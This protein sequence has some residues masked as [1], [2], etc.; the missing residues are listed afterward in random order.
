MWGLLSELLNDHLADLLAAQLLRF[1]PSADPGL[2]DLVSVSIVWAA[3][4]GLVLAFSYRT[5]RLLQAFFVQKGDGRRIHILIADLEGDA[6]GHHTKKL[7]RELQRAAGNGFRFVRYPRV[8]KI[9]TVGDQFKARQSAQ[10]KGRQWLKQKNGDLLIWGEF[11]KARDGVAASYVLEFLSQASNPN[12]VDF[13]HRQKF[14]AEFID[15][16]SSA[17]LGLISAEVAIIWDRPGQAIQDELEKAVQRLRSLAHQMPSALNAE[18]RC[19]LWNSFGIALNNLGR[20]RG[21]EALIEE[22]VAAYR[23]ALEETTQERVPHDWAMTQNNLGIARSTLGRMRGSEVLIEEAIAAYRAA[24]EERTQERVPL[25]WAMTQNN[26]GN[27]LS[28]LGQMRGSEAVI[29]EAVAA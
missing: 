10:D 18:A 11:A 20:M 5:V 25:Q 17:I 13:A 27:A 26:L 15:A 19:A 28:D 6:R 29:E 7:V 2:I 16:V 1:F 12:A 4:S 14:P 3:T 23:A 8:L 24:L 9:R 21:S 22:A